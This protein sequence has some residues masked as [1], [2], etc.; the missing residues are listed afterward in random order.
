MSTLEEIIEAVQHLSRSERVHLQEVLDHL[1]D[2][3][4]EGVVQAPVPTRRPRPSF[5]AVAT[6]GQAASDRIVEERR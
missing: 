2:T 3:A 6:V 4:H 5:R 1:N